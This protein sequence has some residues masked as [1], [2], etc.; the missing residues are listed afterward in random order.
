MIDFNSFYLHSIP[1]WLLR[2]LDG[3]EEQLQNIATKQGTSVNK[4]VELV[5]ENEEIV[6]EM[7]ANLRQTVVAAM[8]KIV[9]RSD[10]KSPSIEGLDEYYS[11]SLVL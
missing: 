9:M 3:L 6:D 4:L 10:G 2:R 1:L 7:K 11:I 5:N 8:A